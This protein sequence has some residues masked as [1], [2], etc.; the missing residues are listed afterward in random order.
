MSEMIEESP[1]TG[2]PGPGAEP[3]PTGGSAGAG[4]TTMSPRA[5]LLRAGSRSLV[6]SGLVATPVGL[7]TLLYPPAVDETLW[8][9]PFDRNTHVAVSIV[10][11]LVHLLKAHGFV[12]LSRV[13]G[14]GRVT[15]VAM[16]VAALGFVIV[17]SCEGI[18]ASL[19]GVPITSTEA[20]NLN[21]GYG[22]GSM[23]F[24]VAS[25]VGGTTIIRKQLLA[26]SGRWSVLLSGAFMIFVVTP[27]L[28]AGRGPAA[29]LA[30][31]G[32]SLFYIW[33]GRALSITL[34]ARHL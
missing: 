7:L 15:Q 16:L 14:A 30:L 8:G 10:L 32:W 34:S 3:T 25:M 18:S 26:G 6:L 19:F 17:A 24:A 20:I 31:T 21:D 4:E 1:K 29:Y 5:S 11:V 23:I 27:A 12:A 28:L 22:A 13:P 33:I 9:H 2:E